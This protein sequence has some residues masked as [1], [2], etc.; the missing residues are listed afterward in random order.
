MHVGIYMHAKGDPPAPH[1]PCFLDT[2]FFT[3]PMCSELFLQADLDSSGYLDRQEF[4]H[5]LKSADLQLSPS[6]VLLDVMGGPL[7]GP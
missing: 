7:I 6:Q 3:S 5:V 2:A 1:F 4:S